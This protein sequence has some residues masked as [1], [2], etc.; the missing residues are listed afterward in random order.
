VTI[1]KRPSIGNGMAR[2]KPV[3]WVKW[4]ESYF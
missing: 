1:A 3:I 4:K 2:D